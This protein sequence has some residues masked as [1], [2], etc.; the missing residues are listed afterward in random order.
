[1]LHE[2]FAFAL[3][4]YRLIRFNQT[5]LLFR[6]HGTG[7]EI[8]VV[9]RHGMA[10][11]WIGGMNAFFLGSKSGTSYRLYSVRVVPP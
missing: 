11:H 8:V 7:E 9:G 3:Y 4:V 1:M 10:W 6:L 5:R 2:A